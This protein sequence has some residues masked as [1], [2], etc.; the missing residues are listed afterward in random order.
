MGKAQ[1]WSLRRS[2]ALISRIARCRFRYVDTKYTI[3]PEYLQTYAF[4]LL[5]MNLFAT[6]PRIIQGH[7]VIDKLKGEDCNLFYGRAQLRQQLINYMKVH[8]EHTNAIPL[9]SKRHLPGGTS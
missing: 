8:I 7:V 3:K 1:C 5:R 2:L 6:R 9:K 4:L